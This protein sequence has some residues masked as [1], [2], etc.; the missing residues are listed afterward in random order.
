M[1]L[2]FFCAI[3]IFPKDNP[4][5]NLKKIY[6]YY[7]AEKAELSK[8][9]SKVLEEKIKKH[10][11]LIQFEGVNRNDHNEIVS[12][13]IKFGDHYFTEGKFNLSRSFYKKVL[14]ISPD[15]WDLYNKIEKINRA[16]GRLLINSKNIS[17]QVSYSK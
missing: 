2:I 12:H 1:I 16:D 4:W 13:L 17:Y 3:V 14:N 7:S 10:L 15:H 6:F 11:N 5:G 9:P 8:E